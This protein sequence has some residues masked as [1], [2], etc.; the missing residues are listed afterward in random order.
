M[1]EMMKHFLRLATAG[2]ILLYL[3]FLGFHVVF[4]QLVSN[5]SVQAVVPP[6]TN[7]FQFEMTTDSGT[8]VHQGQTITYT[9]TY[10]A[11]SSAALGSNNTIVVQY[12]PVKDPSNAFIVDYV[13]GSASKAYGDV[14]PVVDQRNRT[15]SWKLPTLPEGVIDQQ[16]TFQLKASETYSGKI[17]VPFFTK[18]TMSNEFLTM[19]DQVIDHNFVFDPNLV[20]P[21][22]T[23][24]PLPT[25]TPSPTPLFIPLRITDIRLTALSQAAATVGVTT[26]RPTKT[27]IKY[28]TTQDNLDQTAST[29]RYAQYVTVELTNLRQS[30]Q[31]Y[32][33][34]TSTD[35]NGRYFRSEIYTFTTPPSSATQTVEQGQNVVT[36]TSGTTILLSQLLQANSPT[37]GSIILPPGVDYQI[38]YTLPSEASSSAS[39]STFEVLIRND[40]GIERHVFMTQKDATTYLA[41]L[42]TSNSGS[43]D[44]YIVQT[45]EKGNVT[46]TKVSGVRVSQPLRVIDSQTREAIGDARVLL[47]YFNNQAQRFEAVGQLYLGNLNNPQYTDMHGEIHYT[48]PSGTYQADVSA[49]GHKNAT[50]TFKISTSEGD[51]PTVALD[52]DSLSTSYLAFYI[53]DRFNDT[54]TG[55]TQFLHYAATSIRLYNLTSFTGLGSLSLLSFL[56][57][58]LRTSLN[59]HEV[60]PFFLFHLAVVTGRHKKEYIMGIVYDENNIPVANARIE[61]MLLKESKIVTHTTTDKAGRFQMKN[62]FKELYVKMAVAKDGYPIVEVMVQTD[63]QTPVI[64]HLN[65]PAGTKQ[66]SLPLLI[67]TDI[68]GSFFEVFLILSLLAEL[69]FIEAFGIAR[70]LPFIFVSFLNLLLW[71]FY[72]RTSHLK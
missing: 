49:Y 4:A 16:I 14:Q 38:A 72:Q 8:E 47:S 24:K 41:Q 29:N 51:Y 42:Q 34:A 9:I 56:L 66:Q 60:V 58:K 39:T 55:L 67:L 7:D 31:Y 57:F 26:S 71:I 52:P 43:Y 32:F 63:T 70:T 19:P 22:P 45:D 20:P 25:P 69:L 62:S 12:S 10:G 17:G 48:L 18:A 30:T 40:S 5:V 54:M 23:G 1:L 21:T 2:G 35:Q 37:T 13:I 46:S 11:S 50:K 53:N 64:I 59:W 15:I 36:I 6:H 61:V 33:Q 44:I 65:A 27:T 28:G 3:L 68:A